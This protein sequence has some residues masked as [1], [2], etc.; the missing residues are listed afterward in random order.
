MGQFRTKAG[1]NYEM[2]DELHSKLE[3]STYFSELVD[4][5]IGTTSFDALY[6]A[7]QMIQAS[8]LCVSFFSFVGFGLLLFSRTVSPVHVMIWL[9]PAYLLGGILSFCPWFIKK[10]WGLMSVYGILC[11]FIIPQVAMVLLCVFFFKSIG[12][13]ISIILLRWIVWEFCCIPQKT[14]LHNQFAVAALKKHKG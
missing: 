14:S 11:R 10:F 4:K 5:A 2:D 3:M 8:E 7:E 13:L 6:D 12:L 1:L 9:M